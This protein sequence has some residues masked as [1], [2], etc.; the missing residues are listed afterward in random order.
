MR[1]NGYWLSV[2][3]S[4]DRRG[5]PLEAIQAAPQLTEGLT[6]E[7][8]REVARRLLTE[9]NYAVFQLVPESGAQ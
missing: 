6:P 4:Y 5:W 3:G 8:I 2:L 7:A 9:D 1:Q